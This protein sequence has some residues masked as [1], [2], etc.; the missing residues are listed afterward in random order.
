M[1]TCNYFLPL[2][3]SDIGTSF[4]CKY[5][6]PASDPA[7]P[8]CA[9]FCRNTCHNTVIRN[10]AGYDCPCCHNTVLSDGHSAT[11]RRTRTNP[12]SAS[13]MDG[14]CI[15]QVM[16]TIRILLRQPLIGKKRMTRGC[17]RH[18]CAYP[19]TILQRNRRTVQK[20]TFIVDK[21]AFS[22]MDIDTIFTVK[23][24][25]M[26][27]P[28]SLQMESVFLTNAVFFFPPQRSAVE[29]ITGFHAKFMILFQIFAVG[30][31]K[32]AGFHSFPVIH[33]YLPLFISFS[34]TN[35]CNTGN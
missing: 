19:H 32:S 28:P 8:V 23:W 6:T 25:K 12:A 31:V 5:P 35:F 10:I 34:I 17:N 14:L 3:L 15:L 30:I 20:C 22:K 7:H 21:T 16:K 27:A 13:D 4:S 33:V 11:D 29:F 26:A 18:V 9:N 2:S 24:G 1:H